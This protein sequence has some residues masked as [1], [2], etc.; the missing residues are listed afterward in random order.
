MSL[1]DSGANQPPTAPSTKNEMAGL[2]ASKDWSATALGDQNNWSP[3]LK[4]IVGIMTASGFHWSLIL[5]GVEIF[6]RLAVV[7]YLFSKPI[8]EQF[9]KPARST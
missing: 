2:I 8:A 3:S 5:V 1:D 7:W 6:V 9:S 4:L